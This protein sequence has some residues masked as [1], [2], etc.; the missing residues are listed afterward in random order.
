MADTRNEG[1]GI[2][3]QSAMSRIA[4]ADDLDKYIKVTN[5]SAWVALF[6]SLLLLAGLATWSATAVIPTTVELTGIITGNQ[7]LCWVDETTANR[8]QSG[9]AKASVLDITATAAVCDEL[10]CSKAEV[11]KLINSDYLV[12]SI[13]LNDWNYEVDLTLPQEVEGIGDE[14]RPVPVTIIV[15][16]TQPLPLVLGNR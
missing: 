8:I 5:P 1:A 11:E 15:S 14:V 12:D 16:E 4:S 13:T 6:A 7:V 10:P 3:R 2:F 9:G